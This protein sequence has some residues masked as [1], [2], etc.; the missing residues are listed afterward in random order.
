MVIVE[1][2]ISHKVFSHRVGHALHLG[3][4]NILIGLGKICAGAMFVY[5]FLKVLVL[6]HSQQWNLLFT[7]WGLW[8][9][10]EVLGFVLMP[11]MLY[12]KAV[13]EENI[14]LVKVAA[15]MARTVRRT[16]NSAARSASAPCSS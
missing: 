6:C 15:R 13:R 2:S 3:H 10:V 12:F 14:T 16:P 7:G 4:N 1:G 9:L 8:F 11:M 5:F